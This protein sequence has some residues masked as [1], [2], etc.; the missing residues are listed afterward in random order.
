MLVDEVGAYLNHF[1][2]KLHKVVY[3]LRVQDLLPVLVEDL[4][5]LQLLIYNYA[6]PL[7]G[8]ALHLLLIV[9]GM[10]FAVDLLGD[11][12]IQARSSVCSVV[13]RHQGARAGCL[14]VPQAIVLV[15]FDRN[16][17]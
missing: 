7:E 17:I 6:V 10:G 12:F 2:F 4:D 1:L 5:F 9:E 14:R 13:F 8:E 11:R 15:S 16:R 3:S